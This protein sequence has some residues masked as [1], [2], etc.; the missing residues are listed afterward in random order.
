MLPRGYQQEVK[1]WNQ[2]QRGELVRYRLRGLSPIGEL[3][4]TA[5]HRESD[6]Y[7]L[8]LDLP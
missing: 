7:A 5:I 3:V 4:A 2:L 8:D 1:L 6:I